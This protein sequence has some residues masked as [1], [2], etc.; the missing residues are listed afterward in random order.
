[1][2]AHAGPP[3]EAVAYIGR[4][5]RDTTEA[6]AQRLVDYPATPVISDAMRRD[7]AAAADVVRDYGA[8]MRASRNG[9]PDR[10][11]GRGLAELLCAG[12]VAG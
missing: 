4:P 3:P 8:V 2:Y 6:L 11:C 12:G 7:L 5:G 1:M 9:R 10:D